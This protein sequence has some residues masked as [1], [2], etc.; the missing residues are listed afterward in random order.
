[1]QG[2]PRAC[3]LGAWWFPGLYAGKHDPFRYYMGVRGSTALCEQI[4]PLTALDSRLPGGRVPKLVWITPNLCDD[5]HSCPRFIGDRWLG[6]SCPT[7]W[8]ARP[9]GTAACCSS[10]LRAAV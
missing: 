9:E 2:L 8:R 4:Q 10:H 1:M 6:R 7:S 3:F 5:M